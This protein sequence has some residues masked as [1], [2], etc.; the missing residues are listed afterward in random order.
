[1]L[2]G[3]R[4]EPKLGVHIIGFGKTLLWKLF[5]LDKF[6]NLLTSVGPEPKIHPVNITRFLTSEH[7]KRETN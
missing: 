1:M 5:N 3:H 7:P 2:H 6:N 4:E